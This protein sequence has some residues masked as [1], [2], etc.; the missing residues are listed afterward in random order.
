M[1][2]HNLLLVTQKLTNAWCSF[3][4]MNVYFMPMK[5]SQFYGLKMVKFQFAPKHRKEDLWSATVTEHD[6]LLALT[7]EEHL[8]DQETTLNIQTMII[9]QTN[10]HHHSKHFTTGQA[11]VNPERFAIKCVGGR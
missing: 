9:V 7:D 4:M 11:R 8:K 6:G 10:I 3:I 5:A 1:V 2:V